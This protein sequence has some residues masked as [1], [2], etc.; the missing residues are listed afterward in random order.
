MRNG[1][2]N[3][4]QRSGHRVAISCLMTDDRT[5]RVLLMLVSMLFV[6][7]VSRAAR[8]PYKVAFYDRW[9]GIPSEQL[10]DKAYHFIARKE[11]DSALVCYSVV[12]NRYYE[13]E[14]QT[15]K[16]RE[17]S[18]FAMNNIGYLY[19]FYYFDYEKSYHYLLQALKLSEQYGLKDVQSH[20]YLNLANLYRTNADMH[21]THEFDRMILA[22]YKKAFYGSL[23]VK[24]WRAFVVMFYGLAYFAN[25]TDNVPAISREIA[26][27]SRQ[28]IP[29]EVPMLVFSRYLCKEM[30]A[31]RR[32]DDAACLQ[33]LDSMMAHI[34]ASDT[35]ERFRILTL[36]QKARTLTRMSRTPEALTC[37]QTAMDLADQY[38]SKDLQ[39][40]I[41]RRLYEY[42]AQSGNRATAAKYE[43]A[44]LQKKDSLL[45]F[46]KMESIGKMHFLEQLKQVND[47]VEQLSQARKTQNVIL[48]AVLSVTVVVLV[49]TLLLARSYRR[50]KR[51]H[52]LLYR[53]NVEMQAKEDE[54]RRKRDEKYRGSSL[55]E[56]E[57]DQLMERIQAVVENTQEICSDSFSLNRLAELVGYNY[58][59]VSQVINEKY[60]KNFN[61]LL[62]EYRIKEACRR[63]NDLKN[64]GNLTIEGVGMSVGFRSRSNF[65]QTFKQ[66]VGMSPSEYR[67]IAKSVKM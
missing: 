2:N 27:F 7:M 18:L 13:Q 30:D 4:S 23:E 62:N 51:N 38:K 19:F 9:G 6:A 12:A 20:V 45:N 3:G 31:C 24:N 40:Y 14:R 36:L 10:N 52:E 29:A 8:A 66:N 63:L 39:V 58:K 1:D 11:I 57:K 42:Y 28:R 50:L 48:L 54:M 46:S 55:A 43:L 33:Y 21:H 59:Y 61:A 56:D 47:T 49:F 32:H 5:K 22:Y 15:P 26:V 17:R 35:P 16:E 41:S 44:Y 25:T 65:E 60:R 53:A 37:M 67:R 64:Y 34:D